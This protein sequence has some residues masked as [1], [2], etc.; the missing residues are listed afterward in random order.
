MPQ[1]L[2]YEIHSDAAELLGAKGAHVADESTRL[3]N[4]EKSLDAE[5]ENGDLTAAQRINVLSELRKVIYLIS[6]INGLIVPM[7]DNAH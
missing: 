1:G 3:D 2:N 5:Y 7:E 4:L 6:L